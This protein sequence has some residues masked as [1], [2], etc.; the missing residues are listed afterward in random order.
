MLV[1]KLD[2]VSICMCTVSCTRILISALH[3]TAREK[4]SVDTLDMLL[5]R[6]W[7]KHDVLRVHFHVHNRLTACHKYAVCE[8]YLYD[9]HHLSC[10]AHPVW[11]RSSDV[12][13]GVYTIAK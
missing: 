10:A 7:L 4:I 1:I 8:R 12:S 11:G 3:F 5:Q 6:W 2:K 13:Y 9:C